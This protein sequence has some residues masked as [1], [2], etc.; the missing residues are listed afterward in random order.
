MPH[1]YTHTEPDYQNLHSDSLFLCRR[2]S[3]ND[4]QINVT[5][6]GYT[7]TINPDWDLDN[8]GNKAYTVVL[9]E[10][11]ILDNDNIPFKGL[12][13][14][15]LN[16][17][18]FD[19]VDLD[20]PVVDVFMPLNRAY[21]IDRATDIVLT[22]NES[23][24]PNQGMIQLTPYG[25]DHV[26]RILYI[27]VPP[28]DKVSRNR[29]QCDGKVCTI[30]PRHYLDDDAGTNC[31]HSPLRCPLRCPLHCSARC[32]RRCSLRCS[33]RCPLRCPLRCSLHCSLRCSLLT[34]LLVARC[35]LSGR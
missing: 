28:I 12:Q 16:E 18:K 4:N 26:G 10:C 11:F 8:R 27:S 22:F 9:P 6:G 25:G 1:T 35:S 32:L 5:N 30:D 34:P 31:S 17:Y 24:F 7:L 14:A 19:V 3:V 13:R 20:V 2:F 29:L 21:N 33:L 23:V 15:F